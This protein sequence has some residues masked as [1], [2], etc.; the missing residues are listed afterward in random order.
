LK[1]RV[2]RHSTHDQWERS[3]LARRVAHALPILLAGGLTP[4]NVA[5]AIA[6]VSPWGVDVSSG[7][8]TGKQKDTRKM[9]AFIA[10]VRNV[11][12]RAYTET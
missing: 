2:G 9:R 12:S 8:E 1:H 3:A 11:S 4:E 10:E 6:Q 5:E 7:V